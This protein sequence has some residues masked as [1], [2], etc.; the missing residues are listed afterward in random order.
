MADPPSPPR[1]AVKPDRIIAPVNTRDRNYATPPT[2]KKTLQVP[3]KASQE[4]SDE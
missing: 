4:P 1:I 2:A 3:P